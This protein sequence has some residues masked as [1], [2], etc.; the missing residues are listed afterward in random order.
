M[1]VTAAI[2]ATADRV[3]EHSAVIGADGRA[4]SY[5]TIDRLIDGVAQNILQA[6]LT[7]RHVVGLAVTGPD[8]LPGL[9]TALA[10]ARLGIATADVTLPS[11]RLSLC[12]TEGDRPAPAGMRGLPMAQLWSGVGSAAPA[13]MS[14]RPDAILRY[15]ASSGTTGRPKYAAVTHA[16][17]LARLAAADADSA[18]H[19]PVRIIGRG[20][21]A[22]GGLRSVLHALGT[23]ATIVLTNP[24]EVIPAIHRHGVTGL[25]TSPVSLQSILAAMGD[26]PPPPSLAVL[27]VTGAPCP[28]PLRRLARERLGAALVAGAGCM[29]CG[30]LASAPLG[31]DAVVPMRLRPGVEAAALGPDGAVLP[32]G[33]E[34]RLRYRAPGMVGGYEDDEALS[35]EHF[36]D[37]WFISGDV[38]RVADGML[39]LIGREQDLIN[40]G[41]VKVAPFVI[42]E[43]LATLPGVTEAV[44]FGA[45]DAMGVEHIWAAFTATR[46]I[47]QQ[48]LTDHCRM[49]LGAMA[50]RNVLQ[51]PRFPRTESGKVL[52][53][54]LVE[55]ASTR[56]VRGD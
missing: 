40:S 25:I 4:H 7:P 41:G 55:Y 48:E 13:P 22:E 16:L 27:E 50:P 23:G 51:V 53:A 17:S 36:R 39:T 44:A 14:E 15:M 49:L 33:M 35:A 56:T 10:F 45:P 47:G 9:V 42:E 2:R 28:T 24:K 1:N 32:A 8:E 21:G 26:A 6:G 3:P 31:D 30:R 19:G 18:R 20:L 5:R 46:L 34:G 38:G 12:V 29:E 43:A 54:M 52:R 37:G 11:T